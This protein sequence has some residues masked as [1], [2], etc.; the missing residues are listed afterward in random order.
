M[1]VSFAASPLPLLQLKG[2]PSS[3]AE[4]KAP[5]IS[6]GPTA[7]TSVSV[8]PASVTEVGASGGGDEEAM[9]ETGTHNCVCAYVCVCVCVRMLFGCVSLC[10]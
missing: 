1:P 3:G 7:A 2:L 4:G 6:L 5:V 8:I 10:V 9:E